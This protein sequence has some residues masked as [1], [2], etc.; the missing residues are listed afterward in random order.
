MKWSEIYEERNLISSGLWATLCGIR[1]FDILLKW[2]RCASPVTGLIYL[3]LGIIW[4]CYLNK[5][6]SG[7]CRRACRS[8]WSV[9]LQHQTAKIIAQ[10]GANVPATFTEHFYN[11]WIKREK[12]MDLCYAVI[13][14]FVPFYC[15]LNLCF[16]FSMDLTCL[17]FFLLKQYFILFF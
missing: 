17:I 10:K 5:V 13:L 6:K 2:H 4:L 9:K 3:V 7:T 15:H 14:Y 11:D 8:Q 1:V 16:S 12:N